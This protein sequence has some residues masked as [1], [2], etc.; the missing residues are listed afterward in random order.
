MRWYAILGT[1]LMVLEAFTGVAHASSPPAGPYGLAATIT[2]SP[3][4]VL[5]GQIVHFN[6]NVTGG[7]LYNSTICVLNATHQYPTACLNGFDNPLSV[8][9]WH[10]YWFFGKVNGTGNASNVSAVQQFLPAPAACKPTSSSLPGPCTSVIQQ[11]QQ[12]FTYARPGTYEVSLTAYDA[13]FD[14]YITS[15]LVTVVAPTF[16]VKINA[17]NSTA[18]PNGNTALLEGVPVSFN[19]SCVGTVVN[20]SNVVLEWN[21]GDGTTGYGSRTYHSFEERGNYVVTLTGVDYNTGAMNRTFST[22]NVS[23]FAPF[24][25]PS[26]HP[27]ILTVVPGQGTEPVV[28]AGALP[29]TGYNFTTIAGDAVDFCTVAFDLEAI[30]GPNITFQWNFGDGTAPVYTYPFS[31]AATAQYTHTYEVCRNRDLIGVDQPPSID[32]GV[33]TLSSIPYFIGLGAPQDVVAPTFTATSHIYTCPGNYSVTVAAIDEEGVNTTSPVPIVINVVPLNSSHNWVPSPQNLPVGQVAFLDVQRAAGNLLDTPFYNYTWNAGTLGT[34][35]GAVGRTISFK[36]TNQQVGLTIAANTTALPCASSKPVTQSTYVNFTDVKPT[37]GIDSIY[38]NATI[39]ITVEDPSDYSSLNITLLEN[40]VAT[41]NYTLSYPASQVTFQA[42]DFQMSDDWSL[43]IH[44]TPYGSGGSWVDVAFAWTDDNTAIDNYDKTE[45]ASSSDTESYFFDNSNSSANRTWTLS[46]NQAAVG[47][48]LFGSV[49]FFSP[50][51]TNLTETWK[52]GD[53][54]VSYTNTPA[55]TTPGPTFDTWHFESAYNYGANYSFNVTA[56]DDYGMCGS[57]RIEIYNY[58]ALQVNDTAPLV[59]INITGISNLVDQAGNVVA[60]N[61]T[62]EDSP[63]TFNATVTNQDNLTGPATTQ[64]VFGDGSSSGTTTVVH[65]YR[66]AAEYVAVMYATSPGGSTTVAFQVIHVL[67]PPPIANFTLSPSSPYTGEPVKF[68]G[69]YSEDDIYGSPDMEF[70]WVF[71]DGAISGGL[72]PAGLTASHTYI[73]AQSYTASLFVQDAEGATASISRTFTVSLAPIV[74]PY[75]TVLNATVVDDQF[76]WFHLT[77]PPNSSFAQIP[78]INA[79][80]NWGDGSA[81]NYGVTTGHTYLYPGTYTLRVTVTGPN[82][83]TLPIYATVTVK[84]GAPAVSLPYQGAEVYGLQHNMNFTARVLGTYAD[85]GRPWNFTWYWGDKNVS[86]PLSPGG[87]VSTQTH[88]YNYTAPANLSLVVEGPYGKLGSGN[89][90]ASVTINSVPDSDQDGLPDI[91]EIMVSHTSPYLADTQDKLGYTGHGCTDY[92]GSSCMSIPGIGSFNGDDD[93]DGLTNLQEILGTVTGF[94]SNPLDANT[95]GDG[96]PDGSH[97][98]SDSFPA[99]QTIPFNSSVGTAVDP[100]P[101]VAYYGPAVAFN[102]SRLVV[103]LSTG[104]PLTSLGLRLVDPEGRVIPLGAP[105]GPVSTFYLVN[106]TPSNGPNSKYGIY[107]MSVSDFMAP[108]TW[109]VEVVDSSGGPSGI[110]VAA[111]ITVAYHTNPG[112]ADPL[113]QGLLQAHGLTTPVFNCSEVKANSTFPVFDPNTFTVSNISYYPYTEF[114]YKLSVL[115]GVPYV[116]GTNSPLANT[117]NTNSTCTAAGVANTPQAEDAVAS[118][119]GDADF[120]ISPWNAHAAGD[121]L[122]TNGMKA[123]GSKYYDLTAGYYALLDGSIPDV[124]SDQAQGGPYNGYKPVVYP[125]DPVTAYTGPLN[126]TMLSTAGDGIPDSQAPD[127]VAPLGLEVTLKS[128]TDGYCYLLAGLI[129]GPQDIASV[130][131]GTPSGQN[132]PTIYTPAQYGSG[133]SGCDTI[134][135][136]PPFTCDVSFGNTG[137]TF[138]FGNSYF[139]PLNNSQRNFALTFN[140]WQNQ[141]LTNSPARESVSDPGTL[142]AG[143]YFNV[144]GSINAVVQV[145]PLQRLPVV[146]V[147]KTGEL[148]NLP[149]YGY[150]Y[151]GEQRFYSFD[152]NLGGSNPGQSSPSIPA[153]FVQGTNIILESREAALNSSLNGTLQAGGSGLAGLPNCGVLGTSVGNVNITTNSSSSSSDMAIQFSLSADVSSSPSCVSSLLSN[154]GLLPGNGTGVVHGDEYIALTTV[155]LEL[156]GLDAGAMYLAPFEAP[157]GFDS[158]SGTPPTSILSEV[159]TFVVNGINAIRGGILAFANF[160]TSLPGLLVKFGQALLGDLAMAGADLARVA[161]AIVSAFEILFNFIVGLFLE[162]ISFI[163]NMAVQFAKS[164]ASAMALPL[165]SDLY[166]VGLLNATQF[167]SAFDNVTGDP[168]PPALPA[169]VPRLALPGPT[170]EVLALPAPETGAIEAGVDAETAVADTASAG[171]AG[172]AENLAVE[173]AP[174]VAGKSLSEA[175]EL[176][177]LGVGVVGGVTLATEVLSAVTGGDATTLESILESAPLKISAATAKVIA[178]AL[179]AFSSLFIF[180]QGLAFSKTAPLAFTGLTLA[181]TSI[182]L[183]VVAYLMGGPAIVQSIYA[184]VAE[185]LTVLG[186]AAATSPAAQVEGALTPFPALVDVVAVVDTGVDFGE[187]VYYASQA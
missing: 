117:T 149:G 179:S 168:A 38:T 10:L 85:Q 109:D 163:G 144:S 32:Q 89:T 9:G 93:G 153:P 146:L 78:L 185:L 92:V 154:K 136:C 74:P 16:S 91:Y 46:V 110:I 148:E 24:G 62:G 98:F 125:T 101:G 123:L 36:P 19:G 114:Y 160:I 26:P 23:N 6:G 33:Y 82:M 108:G 119:L 169:P 120:G 186:Y 97:F 31:A 4:T 176:L 113:L 25:E 128:A 73:R 12:N 177:K 158:P 130:T 182:A 75:P 175:S 174:T 121:P 166:D 155:Q 134:N 79:T 65:V 106:S 118:Y 100:I 34:S 105:Q 86:G 157:P 45:P 99:N 142:T 55:P 70:G 59:S 27:T 165:L 57:D 14:Y 15:T 72:P 90:T 161:N 60:Y 18:Y 49:V 183:A 180:T 56:C 48:P 64:W 8:P 30:D 116:P 132:E 111:T 84:D 122:L 1:F 61:A 66:Y 150:R 135:L 94:Y 17:I 178:G 133:S 137:Y 37:V 143:A 131:L 11:F 164:V 96:V 129:G 39:T 76:S 67:N 35:W 71:G 140:L 115:Q 88:L 139:L 170:Q 112:R 43:R 167:H 151:I 69:A 159:T 141:S 145:V 47:E 124:S 7:L 184:L 147:N 83:G 87:D 162:V 68:N 29:A 20:C 103:Q 5:A 127:P 58:N 80:W 41:G 156:L 42:I 187:V 102:A 77:I 50:A 13:N 95:A 138:A 172:E 126:P 21:F 3:Q 44:Y 173:E 181:F 53:G 152:L 107:G 40:G 51:Q 22:L 81:F 52:W 2:A 171:L 54:T 28:A 104:G 63:V